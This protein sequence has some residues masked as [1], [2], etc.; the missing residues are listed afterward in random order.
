MKTGLYTRNSLIALLCATSLF[1]ATGCSSLKNT[2]N[3]MTQPGQG[4]TA[5][6]AAGAAVGTGIG[7][8]IGGG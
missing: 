8:L 2:W 3:G 4:A 1:G 6:G 5:G 7:A